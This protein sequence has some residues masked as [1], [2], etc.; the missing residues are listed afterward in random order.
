MAESTTS[1]RRLLGCGCQT[2]LA[3]ETTALFDELTD[4][5][6]VVSRAG[7]ILDAHPHESV[8]FAKPVCAT[9]A[10]AELFPRSSALLLD[11][12]SVSIENRHTSA[13]GLELPLAEGSTTRA[14]VRIVPHGANATLV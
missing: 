13:I 3:A 7:V 10:L 9:T 6:L 4:A 2:S 5:L 14:R 12:L 1:P 8:L 11:R